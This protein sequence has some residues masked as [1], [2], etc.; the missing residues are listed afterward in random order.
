MLDHRP[1]RAPGPAFFFTVRLQPG[2][3]LLTDYV[4]AFGE[5]VRHVR[6]RRPFNVEA[7]VVLPDHAHA[8]WTMPPD[9]HDCLNR[10]REIKIGFSKLVAKSRGPRGALWLPQFQQLAIR[11]EIHLAQLIDYIHANPA[12][13]GLVEPGAP[14]PWSSQR[15]QPTFKAGTDV[16]AWSPSPSRPEPPT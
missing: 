11:D 2:S 5:A 13:H 12:H 3:T 10:W 1:N 6:A 7:W 15:Q 14:W 9:D 16:L 4:A 8:I